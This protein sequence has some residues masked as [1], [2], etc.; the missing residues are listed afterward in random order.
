M[1]LKPQD[2]VVA[3]KLASS[4]EPRPPYSQLAIELAMSPSEAFAAVERALHAGLL[5][6]IGAVERI[7]RKPFI[8]FLI[9]GVPYAFPPDRGPLSRGIPT[10][11]AAPP[12][13]RQISQGNEP[14]PVWPWPEGNVRGYAFSPLYKHAPAAALR[15][16][17]FYE[18]LALVDA[19]RGGRAREREIARKELTSRLQ[20]TQ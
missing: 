19:L 6:R 3:L 4:P 17:K 20:S 5:V 14:P 10:A 13:N 2:V 1:L 12:L 18:L 8:E 7:N 16:H 15:D 9:H 11:H